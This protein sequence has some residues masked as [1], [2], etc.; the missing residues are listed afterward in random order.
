MKLKDTDIA[1]KSIAGECK[2]GKPIVYIQTTGGLHAVFKKAKDNQIEAIAAAPHIGIMKW[3]AEKKE[4]DLKW[5]EGFEN[6][7]LNKSEQVYFQELR[8]MIFSPKTET[9]INKNEDMYLVYDYNNSKIEL[10]Q[11]EELIDVAKSSPEHLLIRKSSL[12]EG[13]MTKE[14]FLLEAKDEKQK[15]R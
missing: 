13:I 7:D 10:I 4:P 11:K 8:K 12:E 9:P 5:K 1:V 15:T 2:D 6:D 14:D 3:L